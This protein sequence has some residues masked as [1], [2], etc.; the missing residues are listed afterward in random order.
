MSARLH[1][2]AAVIRDER[3]RILISRRAAGVHQGGLWEFPGGK[4][5]PGEDVQAALRRELR[6]E[7]GIEAGRLSPLIRVPWDYPDRQVLLDVWEVLDFRGTPHGREGQPLRWVSLEDLSGYE[8]PAANRPIRLAAQLPDCYLITPEPGDVPAFLEHL[9]RLL[10]KGIRL[11]QLRAKAMET[12]ALARLAAEAQA[13]CEAHGAC[14]LLNGRADLAVAV[15]AAGVHLTSAQLMA[16]KERPL[17][18]PFLCAAS[19]HDPAELQRAGEL[20]LD[21]AVLAPVQPT[22]SHSEARPLGWNRFSNCCEAAVLPVYALGGVG[23]GDVARARAG[24]GQGIAAIRALWGGM[25]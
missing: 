17:P 14:L 13:L 6:E 24:G 21:F 19:C 2:A 12:G 10:E 18:E 8:F 3:G 11:V 4:L 22:A 23:P 5:E 25:E 9:Q 7:L 15:G 1:V 16:A 20:G